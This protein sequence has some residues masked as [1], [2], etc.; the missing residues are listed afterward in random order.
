[1]TSS[2][3]ALSESRRNLASAL[4]QTLI[5]AS[6]FISLGVGVA[7][8]TGADA[9]RIAA[10]AKTQYRAGAFVYSLVGPSGARV[11]ALKCDSLN[12]A[13]GITAAGGVM[14][15]QIVM[16]ESQP[17]AQL[18]LYT[19]TP[20][21]I[22][23]AWPGSES[24]AALST[25]AGNDL[26][27]VGI[28]PGGT[29]RFRTTR[30]E[31]QKM[32]ID[33]V[34]LYPAVSGEGRLLVEVAPPTGTLESCLVLVSPPAARSM[35][36]ALRGY[37]GAGTTVT[38][39]LLRSDLVAD[40]QDLFASRLSGLG[41]LAAGL[42]SAIILVGSWLARRRDFALY[43]LIGFSER[44]V[45]MMLAIEATF[46]CFL[47][48]QLGLIIGIG[49]GGVQRMGV[50]PLTAQSLLVDLARFDL[51]LLALPAIGYLLLPR[52]SL[53]PTLLGK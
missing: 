6:I 41:W 4:A 24:E 34:A 11:D 38:D 22:A 43:R 25:F 21:F 48:S 5:L 27:D 49:L 10:V 47:P 26:I 39:V 51:A 13:N 20:G 23:A 8:F 37:F 33:G 16:L 53:L 31:M 18:R 36:D 29:V 9:G 2:A 17:D 7:T 40:P 14:A 44:T 30:G 15:N 28:V 32:Q 19:A 3:L 52:R 46:V 42:V 1:M 35:A 12:G 45:F 50:D